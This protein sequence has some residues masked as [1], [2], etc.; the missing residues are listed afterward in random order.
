MIYIQPY[1][2]ILYHFMI[3]ISELVAIKMNTSEIF[4]CYKTITASFSI[5]NWYLMILIFISKNS[6]VFFASIFTV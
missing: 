5:S 3:H 1:M 2:D 4:I 6:H